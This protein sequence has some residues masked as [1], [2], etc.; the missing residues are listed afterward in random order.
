VLIAGPSGCGKSTLA[1]CINGLIPFSYK[2]E[3]TGSLT[4]CGRE[5]R[6]M[7]LFALSRRVG[8]V[9]Q[10]QDGQFI[11]LTVAEDLAFAMENDCVPT[12]ELH[13]RVKEIAG[14]VDIADHL[15]HAPGD[16]SGGQK[17]RVSLGGVLV[18]DVDI[19]LFDEP[20]ANL[21]PA[22]GRQAV[23]LI[24]RVRRETNA[25]VILIEHRLEDVLAGGVD[26]V[27]LMNDGRITAD[28][29][30]DALVSSNLLTESGI[31][32][33]LYVT[34]LKYAGVRVTPEMHPGRIDTL[35]L[36]AEDQAAVQRW[37][38]ARQPSPLPQHEVLLDAEHIVFSYPNGHPA[39][40]DISLS[41]GKGE[42]L[43]IVGTQR[44][45]QI[46]VFQAALRLRDAAAR[47]C[48]A[49]R[50]RGHRRPSPSRSARIASAT[51][52]RTPTR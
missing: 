27:I 31:R 49:C 39:L 36:R 1:H 32:E 6:D 35:T 13:R 46:Y 3:S 37:F 8:T 47:H 30:P 15:D 45:G 22:A 34:A 41:I 11:G 23:E 42:M 21:D 9:L 38:E 5:T 10:D 2:G 16:L 52:C 24:E 29:S 20:L 12:D 43:A 50:R 28:L 40:R 33:P 44:R 17:Q 51:S 19:L 14:V 4:V 26:R 25:T 48:C 7:S 18:D